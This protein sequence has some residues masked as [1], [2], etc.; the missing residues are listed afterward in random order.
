MQLHHDIDCNRDYDCGFVAE[1]VNPNAWNSAISAQVDLEE[2]EEEEGGHALYP[3]QS[4]N[5]SSS[6]LF[7]LNNPCIEAR[8]VF[9]AGTPTLL[10][11]SALVPTRK[12]GLRKAR[13]RWLQS[14]QGS[15]QIVGILGTQG[16]QASAARLLEKPRSFHR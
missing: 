16:A 9:D 12:T 10:L 3:F 6:L 11:G 15:A 13:R 14:E 1:V 8:L 7:M 4:Q 5:L 2:E